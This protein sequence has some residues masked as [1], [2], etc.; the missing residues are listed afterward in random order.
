MSDDVFDKRTAEEFQKDSSRKEALL[1]ILEEQ[2]ALLAQQGTTNLPLFLASLEWHRIVPGD[3]ASELRAS[4]S[5]ETIY[6]GRSCLMSMVNRLHEPL[7]KASV[8]AEIDDLTTAL[9]SSKPDSDFDD[10][11]MV[12]NTVNLPF[13]S[14]N[15]LRPEG[16]LDLWL[17]AAAMELTD[18]P[19]CVRYGLSV[20]LDEIKDGRMLPVTKPFGLWRRKIAQYRYEDKS[21]V[22][23]RYIFVP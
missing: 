23:G 13:E 18:K 16:W 7:Q 12:G 19:A 20:P 14:L 4:F 22:L 5:S 8:D 10:S 15:R 6:H 3:E 17:I 2:V 11:I 21:D 1:P 9:L